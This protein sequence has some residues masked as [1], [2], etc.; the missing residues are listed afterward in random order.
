MWLEIG[1]WPTLTMLADFNNAD[2]QPPNT[3][4]DNF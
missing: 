2:D 4:H 1:L 3:Q